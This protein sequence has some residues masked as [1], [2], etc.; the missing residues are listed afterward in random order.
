MFSPLFIRI[1]LKAEILFSVLICYG[2]YDHDYDYDYDYAYY[3]YYYYYYY[4]VQSKA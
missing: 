4:I 2:Y 1:V 3:Y